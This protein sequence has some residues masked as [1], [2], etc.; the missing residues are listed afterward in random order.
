MCSC[1]GG[2]HWIFDNTSAYEYIEDVNE[3]SI[4]QV[5]MKSFSVVNAHTLFSYLT[6]SLL[7]LSSQH[8]VGMLYSL[9]K[10]CSF[11]SFPWSKFKKMFFVPSS[12]HYSHFRSDS[13]NDP[14]RAVLDNDLMLFISNYSEYTTTKSSDKKLH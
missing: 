7:Q 10:V 1:S 4:P 3:T 9:V 12:T 8:T 5:L 2:F 11:R 14:N 13:Y 6:S